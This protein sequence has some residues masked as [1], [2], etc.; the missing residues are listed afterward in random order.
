MLRPGDTFPCLI[1]QLTCFSLFTGL[2]APNQAICTT[3]PASISAPTLQDD[4]AFYPLNSLLQIKG[5]FI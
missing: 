2:S 1:A 4:D 5:G 3:S